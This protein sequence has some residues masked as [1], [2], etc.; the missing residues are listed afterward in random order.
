MTLTIEELKARSLEQVLESVL[1]EQEILTVKMPG[2][3]EVIIQPKQ[4]LEPLPVLE[5]FVPAGWKD[6]IYDEPQ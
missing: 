3:Q 4:T 5:G 2:G 6:A 1:K